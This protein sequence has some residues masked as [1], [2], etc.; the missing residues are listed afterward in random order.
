MAFWHGIIGVTR[1]CGG[2]RRFLIAR[3][4]GRTAIELERERNRATATVIRLLPPDSELLEYEPEGRLRII[5]MSGSA[6]TPPI[7]IA[8]TLP[9]SSGE[10]DR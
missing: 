7:Q 2:L 6:A 10:H 1:C 9:R 3:A 8:E 4:R 5:R